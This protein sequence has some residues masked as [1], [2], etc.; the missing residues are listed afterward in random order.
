[1][2]F[3][4]ILLLFFLPSVILASGIYEWNGQRICYE[5]FVPCGKQLCLGG[6]LQNGKCVNCGEHAFI[7]CQFCHFFIML[8]DIVD[9]ILLK[10]VPLV[11]TIMLVV[12]GIMFYFA[13]TSPQSLS[14]AK[15]I[16]TS[17]IIGLVIIYC[18][19]LIV[20]TILDVLGVA[21]WTGLENWWEF[22]CK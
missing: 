2:K 9:F 6:E 5:G 15:S 17:A 14:R 21:E 22:S 4:I 16:L 10:I 3:V 11:G 8:D 19:W 1:M 18:S 13:G 20:N 7:P 12:G